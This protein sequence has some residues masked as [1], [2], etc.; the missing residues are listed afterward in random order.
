MYPSSFAAP[1]QKHHTNALEVAS[2]GTHHLAPLVLAAGVGP[3]SPPSVDAIKSTLAPWHFSPFARRSSGCSR[4]PLQLQLRQLESCHE[5]V[6][7]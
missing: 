6:D 4:R 1:P 5:G 3:A 2:G 7:G